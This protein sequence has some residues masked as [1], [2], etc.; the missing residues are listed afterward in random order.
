MN[1][2]SPYIP[3]GHDFRH[4]DNMGSIPDFAS[5]QPIGSIDP[6]HYA[7][8][9][10]KLDERGNANPT[11]L[12]EAIMRGYAPPLPGMGMPQL[13]QQQDT[14]EDSDSLLLLLS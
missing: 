6:T 13:A 14:D 1:P 5:G 11:S 3:P 8:W 2:D 9:G 12:P 4:D 7:P 10:W